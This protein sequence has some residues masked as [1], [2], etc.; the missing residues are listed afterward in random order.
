MDN[1]LSFQ[2]V[3]ITVYKTQIASEQHKKS[4]ENQGD[5]SVWYWPSTT[6]FRRVLGIK[7]AW[8]VIHG[9]W[10]GK[11]DTSCTKHT[12]IAFVYIAGVL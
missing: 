2:M 11:S 9:G 8:V 3:Q 10:R 7:F 4:Q 1:I 5:M 6:P 12:A